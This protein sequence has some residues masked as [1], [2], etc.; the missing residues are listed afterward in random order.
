MEEDIASDTSGYFKRILVALMAA[1]RHEPTEQQLK[2]IINRGI[3]SVIDKRAADAD[4]Q[5]LYDAGEK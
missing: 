5:K 4:A 2:D 3:D 1:H